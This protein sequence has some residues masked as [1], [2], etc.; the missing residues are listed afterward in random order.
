MH[1]EVAQG[2]DWTMEKGP[3][4]GGLGWL[5]AVGAKQRIEEQPRIAQ[6]EWLGPVLPI[7]GLPLV[8]LKLT[9]AM[10]IAVHWIVTSPKRNWNG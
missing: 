6:S 2:S 9:P 4:S 5:F 8:W 3:A 10:T 7:G 1:R